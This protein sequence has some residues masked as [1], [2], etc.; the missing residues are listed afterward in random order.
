MTGDRTAMVVSPHEKTLSTKSQVWLG[1]ILF[2]ACYAYLWLVVEPRLIYEGFGTIVLNAPVFAADWQSLK[3]ALGLPGGLAVYAY[4]FLSQGL[5]CSWLGAL[6]ILLTALGVSALARLHYIHAGHSSPIPLLYLPAIMIFMLYNHHDHP[7]EVCL[8]LS[9]GLL[10]AW[11]FEQVPQRRALLRIVIFCLLGGISYWLGGT[12]A[13][14]IFALMTAIYL[15]RRRAWLA[16]LLALPA[17][18]GVIWGLAD[19]VFHLSPQ[20][21]FLTL[22][23]FCRDW[24]EGLG[25]LS[26]VLILLLYAFVPATVIFLSLWHLMPARKR[27]AGRAHPRKTRSQKAHA[28]HASRLAFLAHTRRLTL[29]AL[30]VAVLIVGLYGSYDKIHSQIVMMNALALRGR[31]PEVLQHAGRLPQN[32]YS[33]YANH[34]VDRALYHAGRLG[35]EMFCFPQNPHAVLL[36]HEEDESCMTQLKMCDTF[37]EVGNVDLAEK[38]ASEFLVAKGHLPMVLEKLAWINIIKGQED[39]A[40]VY[41]RALRKDL[42]HRRRAEALLNGL[43]HGFGPAEAAYIRRI[44]SYIR[45]QDSGRLNR[46]SIEEMLTGLLAQNPGNRMAFEYL[47]ACYLLA[48]RV[49]KITANTKYL[50]GL[51]YREIPTLYEEA[52]LIYYGAQRVPLDPDK[53]AVSRRTIERYERFVQLN[54]SLRV[55]HPEPALQQLA[56]E[57][58]TSYFFYYRF[59]LSRPASNP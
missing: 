59:T 17:T 41:L 18:A 9:L 51:G 11:V 26:R 57:F 2:L 31:W 37:T 49:D 1:T 44:N 28:A 39:T 33:I 42:I 3:E 25:L 15:L 54:N 30:P 38:L 47:M 52:M 53:L 10:L 7:L 46:E 32:V 40:R 14:A 35:Y 8:T 20:Q 34:D 24:V 45:R 5:C 43:D 29:P 48:G 27:G 36:T 56:Q 50:A 19:Y 55:S 12:G 23:P 16:A 58:G 22:T 13:A 6:I 21:V 4:G